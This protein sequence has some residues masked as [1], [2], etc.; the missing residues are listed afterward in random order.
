MTTNIQIGRRLIP[1]EHIAL[2]EPFD[3]SSQPELR[4]ERPFQNRVVLIN[5]ERTD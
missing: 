5:R 1:L 3:P 2:I 4:S